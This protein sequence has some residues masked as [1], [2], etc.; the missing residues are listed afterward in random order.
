MPRGK[1][2]KITTLRQILHLE[3]LGLD[4]HEI[5]SR[6]GLNRQT[7]DRAKRRDE[8]LSLKRIL[9]EYLMSLSTS[10]LLREI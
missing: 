7:I 4:H 3:L 5:A 8:F 1:S 9:S 2:L 6:L 10:E